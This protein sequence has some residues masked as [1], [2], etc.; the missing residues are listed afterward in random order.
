MQPLERILDDILGGAQIHAHEQGQ[1]DEFQLMHPEQLSH[2]S[3]P[4]RPRPAISLI[5]RAQIS[6]PIGPPGQFGIHVRQ[7]PM[8]DDSLHEAAS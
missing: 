3:R 2:I 1:S 4:G 7:T 5:H 6:E 8:G